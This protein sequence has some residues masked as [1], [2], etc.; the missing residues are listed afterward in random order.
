MAAPAL[1]RVAAVVPCAGR[2]PAPA[3][4]DRLR[5]TVPQVLV[6]DDGLAGDHARGLAELARTRGVRVLQSQQRRG[7]GHAL[8]RAFDALRSSA[9]P[10]AAVCTIDA[11]GQHPPEL[12]PEFLAA[13]R[14]ADLVIGDRF[15]GGGRMPLVRRACNRLTSRIVSGAAG[16]P[17]PD[18]QCGMRLLH[19]AALEIPF[20][21]GAMES[22][23]RHLKTCLAA[24]VRVAWIPIPAIYDGAPSTFRPFRDSLAVLRAAVR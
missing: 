12:I 20:P 11:D 1:E 13:A 24:G 22:E 10:P 9:Q 3:L 21:G 15:S 6:V 4:L 17:V 7:K 19:G 16:A 14:E 23:T 8:A 5:A 18:S 2:P